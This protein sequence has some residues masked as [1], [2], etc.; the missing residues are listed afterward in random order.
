MSTSRQ[1]WWLRSA[2]FGSSSSDSTTS[3]GYA[4]L[5]VRWKNASDFCA[6]VAFERRIVGS[7]LRATCT[8][9]LAQRNCCDLKA[10]IST[11]SSA[12]AVISGT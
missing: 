6:K 8:E 2:R 3:S 5:F 7:S 10:D 4:R 12:G 9:P 1:P 11:G